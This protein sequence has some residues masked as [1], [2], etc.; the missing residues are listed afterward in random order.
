MVFPSFEIIAG[1]LL[2]HVVYLSAQF[3]TFRYDEQRYYALYEISKY[4]AWK[5]YRQ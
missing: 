2:S 1:F 4:A 3:E 5:I